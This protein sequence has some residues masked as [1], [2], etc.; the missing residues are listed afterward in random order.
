MSVAKAA[1]LTYVDYSAWANQ[2][3]LAACSVLTAE[4]LGVDLGAS[5]G[6]VIATLR[7]IYYSERVWLNRLRANSLPPLNEMGDQ[8]R[9]QD[10]PPEPGLPDLEQKWPEVWNGLH[11]WLQNV[12]EIELE[13]ELSCVRPNDRDFRISRWKLL[14]HMVNHS[15]LHR[16][17]VMQLLRRLG[18][19]PPGTDVFGYYL[20]T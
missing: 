11:E 18:K 3:L 15:T 13:R 19:Q 8:R 2:Q 7:H 14:L 16:G 9:F 6:S 20:S 5:H 10:S 12:P 1:L 4:E 17:Q